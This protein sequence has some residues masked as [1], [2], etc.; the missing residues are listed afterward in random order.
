C[1]FC[2]NCENVE[3]GILCFNLKGARYAILNQPV[4]K[5]G[6]MRVKRMLL[7]YINGELERKGG[8]ERSIFALGPSSTHLKPEQRREPAVP[9]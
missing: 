4:T 8:L 7:S 3:E 1:L 2:H 9:V 6:Y 5:E